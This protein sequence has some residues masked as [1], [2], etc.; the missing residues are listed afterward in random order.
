[1]NLIAAFPQHDTFGIQNARL[2]APG[3]PDRSILYQ[4]VFRRGRAQMPPLV[5]RYVDRQAA[6]MIRT[7]IAQMKPE[8]KFV[9]HW[10]IEDLAADIHQVEQ[11]RSFDEGK[12][13]FR[14]VGCVQCH[15]FQKVGGGAGPD[16]SGITQRQ[17]P[18]EIL[19]SIL[20][21]SRKIIPQYA[22]T[23]V[24]MTSGRV[25]EG[26]I[27]KEAEDH[28]LLRTADL[29]ADPLFL[30]K[31]DIEEQERSP[32]S[33]MPDQIVNSLKKKEIFDLLAY[34]IADGKRGHLAFENK[35]AERENDSSSSP[36]T[37]R[38]DSD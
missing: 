10:Q 21:P 15:R 27:E 29:F 24:Y 28:I 3:S 18:M 37:P 25:F 30:R 22:S 1:M 36:E 6:E 16:L 32:K 8:R 7:W 13:I 2:V 14:T 17:K 12:N 4:R 20:E 9:K 19:E 34:L 31:E 35:E 38:S 5:T 33:I 23:I 26:R 11:G